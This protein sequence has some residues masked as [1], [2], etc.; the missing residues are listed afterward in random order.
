MFTF[1]LA[2]G[3]FAA[4]AFPLFMPAG[5]VPAFMAFLG[6]AAFFF[7]FPPPGFILTALVPPG[8]GQS[9]SHGRGCD[10]QR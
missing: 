2:P 10:E 6:A 7:P 3:Y 9:G 4:A 1:P 5:V 8:F